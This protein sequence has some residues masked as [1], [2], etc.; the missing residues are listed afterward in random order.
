MFDN[1]KKG[2]I[3]LKDLQAILY[4]AFSMP[5]EDVEVLFKKIDSKNDGLITFGIRFFFLIFISNKIKG[6]YM[7]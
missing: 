4:S 2:Y 7:F 3:S 6:F 5:S 1:E